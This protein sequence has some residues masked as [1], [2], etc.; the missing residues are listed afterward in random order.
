MFED[1]GAKNVAYHPSEESYHGSVESTFVMM[2]YMLY[3]GRCPSPPFLSAT[4]SH[5]QASS[6]PVKMFV[7]VRDLNSAYTSLQ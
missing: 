7:T 5:F 4:S 3:A 2:Y 1:A 6:D